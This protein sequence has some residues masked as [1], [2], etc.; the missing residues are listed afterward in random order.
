MVNW[1][2][3]LNVKSLRLLPLMWMLFVGPFLNPAW[4]FSWTWSPFLQGALYF[5]LSTFGLMLFSLPCHLH[6]IM[7][8]TPDPA[9]HSSAHH[10]FSKPGVSASP[11]SSPGPCGPSIPG[12]SRLTEFSI[13]IFLFIGTPVMPCDIFQSLFTIFSPSHSLW[14]R[15]HF[16]VK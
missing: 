9:P 12:S 8:G 6:H 5:P 13:L 15:P 11:W 7:A 14:I 10:G 16:P 2:Y 3:F 1:S 4:T